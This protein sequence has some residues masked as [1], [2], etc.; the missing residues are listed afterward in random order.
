MIK[1]IEDNNMYECVQL[2]QKSMQ[3]NNYQPYDRNERCW[4]QHLAT[5][6]QK[7]GEGSPMY[8]AIGDYASCGSLRGFMLANAYSNF[9]TQEWVMDVVDCIVDHNY[10]NAFTVT[11][12]FNY[13]LD[14][15]KKHGGK[16][17]RADSIRAGDKAVEYTE[18]L[19]K[20][21]NAIPFHGVH[22]RIDR[23]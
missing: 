18:F 4:M 16:Y 1:L 17:W 8:L 3:D 10:N 15:V 2:M 23:R 6:I 20:K 5:H 11:R 12:L 14:H 22:G 7:Q 19:A 21:Y 9:Y 13:M